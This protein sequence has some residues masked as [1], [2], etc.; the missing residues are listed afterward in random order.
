[1]H[2]AACLHFPPLGVLR[3]SG[4]EAG[5][6]LHRLLT[7]DIQTLP[8]GAWRM[9]GLCSPKGRLLASMIVCREADDYALMMS[10]DLVSDIAQRLARFILRSAVSLHDESA[11][12]RAVGWV[13][14]LSRLSLPAPGE[15]ALQSTPDPATPAGTARW[16]VRLDAHRAF[17]FYPASTSPAPPTVDTGGWIR[18]EIE[19]GQPRIVAATQDLFVPQMLHFDR[20]PVH[21][22]SYKKGC[23]PGQE[24]VA[25]AHYL[26][27]VKRGMVRLHGPDAA[28]GPDPDF[29]AVFYPGAALFDA[30]GEGSP[31]GHLV[32]CA[33]PDAQCPQA[34]ALGVLP[35]ALIAQA[36]IRLCSGQGYPLRVETLDETSD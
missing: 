33:P 27:Q 29:A 7:Q 18:A 22:V 1:M 36:D 12:Y 34:I 17:A 3:V 8:H 26:G 31:C 30:A 14:A 6:F 20:A 15:I 35:L 24:I 2:S 16:V 4:P 23:Y 32:L 21:G 25:R 10:A 9:A 28:A 11:A 19:A 5:A 13:G